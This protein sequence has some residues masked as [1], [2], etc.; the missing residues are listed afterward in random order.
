MSVPGIGAMPRPEGTA[1][2]VWAPHAT[3]VSVIGDFNDW[4]GRAHELARE[5][6][7]YWYGE[8]RGAHAGQQYRFALATPA[9]VVT[10]IDPRARQV[11]NSVGNGV[12][13]A[14]DA[15][16]WQ[17]DGFHCPP[18]NDLVIYEL[19]VGSFDGGR[20]TFAGLVERLGHF[21][22]LGVNAL[23]LMPVMEFAGDR[24]WGYN[25]AHPFAVESSYGGPDGLK[26]LVREAH[27]HGI[28]VIV[29][30]VYN[31]FG[32]SDLGLWQ[33]D[34][35]SENGK[36]GIYF[37]NDDRSSTPW[38]DTRPDYGRQEV[39]EYIRDNALM[40][41]EE[42][43]VDGLR[44]DMTP[45]IRDKDG[46]G[47]DLPDGWSLLRAVNGTIRETHPD[48]ITIAEDLKGDYRLT[49][50]DEDGAL[51]HAQWDS[52]FVHPVRQA[53][54]QPSDDDRS[55]TEI[56]V[57]VGHSYGDAFRRVIYTE[58]HDEVANGQQRV[59]SEIDEGDPDGWFA[60]KRSTAAACLVFTAPG[61]P[62]VFQGQEFLEKGWFRDDVPLDWWRNEE[63]QGIVRL[64]GDLARLRRNAD[65]DTR[66]LQGQGLSVHHVDEEAN[67][68]AFHRWAEGG[69]GDDVVVVAN[70]SVQ[71]R[72]GVPI[73]MPAA[74]AWRLKFNS[75]S[76]HYSDVFHGFAA[77]DV[78]A[79]PEPLDDK[80]AHALVD[81]GPYTVLV[82]S[83]A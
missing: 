29:D 58:S 25:P 46:N 22:H 8:V 52:L 67:L 61:I 21:A 40:W 17:G 54:V 20:P 19:H 30:V 28:A 23:E 10:R 73:G 80:D 6:G 66:G 63:F 65:G 62:M 53:T 32:P 64:Y 5:D 36:G 16:D 35:W 44:Y 79:V 60:Q 26:Y 81:I 15:F 11:T 56:A 9:G 83:R 38:G 12:I 57:A 51:F 49:N 3:E 74:G 18:H 72:K 33:F 31:H 42:Y 75:D 76:T 7:G 45:F 50:L 41:L 37:Y 24:S 14:R 70:L 78:E 59:P 4:D 47:D 48:V 39:R 82:Y 27:R 69:V 68:L 13:Y 1:F 77:H 55:V 71:E 2:R 43:H 34:G